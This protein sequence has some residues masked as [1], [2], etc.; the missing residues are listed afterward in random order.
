[1]L[2]KSIGVHAN[3]TSSILKV[4]LGFSAFRVGGKPPEMSETT[5]EKAQG[6]IRITGRCFQMFFIFT[7][8][9][10]RFTNIFQRGW[11]H[12][13]DKGVL[14]TLEIII[15]CTILIGQPLRL[16]QGFPFFSEP[17]ADIMHWRCSCFG[18]DRRSSL[19][20]GSTHAAQE[21]LFYP[22]TEL[23]WDAKTRHRSRA[24]GRASSP[25]CFDWILLGQFVGGKIPCKWTNWN[26]L[27]PEVVG[28]YLKS[29]MLFWPSLLQLGLIDW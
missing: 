1:M 29:Q 22:R 3:S 6:H 11:N 10:G 23:M 17:I 27:V 12:Q 5:W 7:P 15:I 19:P 14:A 28:R 25:R 9:W 8:I 24:A 4:F 18:W 2:I 16:P 13:L 21:S 26:F 20:A